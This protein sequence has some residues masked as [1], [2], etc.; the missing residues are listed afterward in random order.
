[1]AEFDE[2]VVQ[3]IT[4]IVTDALNY[5]PEQEQ[6][7]LQKHREATAESMKKFKE[8]TGSTYTA[9]KKKYYEKNKAVLNAKRAEQI[10]AQRQKA[11]QGV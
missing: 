9:S 8:L 10:K 11:K 4:A 5:D 2:N 3:R 6:A 1:M 7:Y